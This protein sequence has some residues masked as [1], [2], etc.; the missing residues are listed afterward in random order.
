MVA[1]SGFVLAMMKCWKHRKT[2]MRCW[3]QRDDVKDYNEFLATAVCFLASFLVSNFIS[4]V[5]ALAS[6]RPLDYL[7]FFHSIIYPLWPFVTTLPTIVR[8]LTNVQKCGKKLL[9]KRSQWQL[10]SFHN[11]EHIVI[12]IDGIVAAKRDLCKFLSQILKC[13]LH[14]NYYALRIGLDV[15]IV[16]RHSIFD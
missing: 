8:L 11:C 4:L 5:I 16:V 1:L 15:N 10:C 2:V 7:L 12:I 14:R 9:R 13:P 6:G 3:K